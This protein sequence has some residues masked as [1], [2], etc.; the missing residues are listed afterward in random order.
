MFQKH[1]TKEKK[2]LIR[3]KVSCFSVESFCITVPSK[4]V[5]EPSVFRKVLIL[6]NFT[7]RRGSGGMT[8]FSTFFSSH[9]S[10]KFR[11]GEPCDSELF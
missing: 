4:V 1:S 10:Q 2:L 6:K 9:I 11:R 8:A 5:G 7:H 3:G